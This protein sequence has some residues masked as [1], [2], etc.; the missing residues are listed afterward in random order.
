MNNKSKILFASLFS[1]GIILII[2][3]LL[4]INSNSNDNSKND[5]QEVDNEKMAKDILEKLSMDDFVASYFDWST[6][7]DQNL[8]DLSYEN[9]IINYFYGNKEIEKYILVYDDE[10][11]IG[12]MYIKYDDF[13]RI[14]K[15]IFNDV[16][17]YNYQNTTMVFPNMTKNESGKYDVSLDGAH[18]CDLSGDTTNCFV[19]VG[20]GNTSNY[21][22]E[23]FNLDIDDNVIVGNVKKYYDVN[24]KNFYVDGTFEFVFE[25]VS[26]NYV[27]KSFKITKINAQ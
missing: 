16:P 6:E 1:I 2:L 24:D 17:Q 12:T 21:G 26:N 27:A 14:S 18:V 9:G 8:I 19:L 7:I 25:K 23:F 15:K 3:G 13:V 20:S 22:A 11:S 10:N 4:L 5:A